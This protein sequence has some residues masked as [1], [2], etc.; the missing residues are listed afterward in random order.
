MDT[1]FTVKAMKSTFQQSECTFN[2]TPC[3]LMTVIE[4]VTDGSMLPPVGGREP[5]V[6]S[7]EPYHNPLS[8]VFDRQSSQHGLFSIRSLFSSVHVSPSS[9]KFISIYRYNKTAKV[10]R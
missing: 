8:F 10:Q 5:E 4:S 6:M 9:F 2:R 3:D 7:G 1:Q